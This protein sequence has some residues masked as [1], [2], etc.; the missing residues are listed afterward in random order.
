MGSTAK[1]AVPLLALGAIGVAT[2]GFGL[3]GGG[4]AAAGAGGAAAGAGA[5]AGTAATGAA[6]GTAAAGTAAGATGAGAAGASTG[7]WGWLTANSAPIGLGMGA[8]SALG[9]M[10]A[11]DQQ[12]Q[13]QEAMLAAQASQD[14]LALA[15]QENKVQTNLARTLAA[16]NVYFA[17]GG[18]APGSGSALAAA[19]SAESQAQRDLSSLYAQAAGQDSITGLRRR[20]LRSA[21]SG[22][23]VGSL[24]DF[25]GDVAGYFS[26]QAKIR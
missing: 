9:S 11:A 6:A 4:A 10:Q 7:L 24:L 13:Q 8:L 16:Q 2:G 14:K 19:N 18:V 23:Q 12:T 26:K 5:A 20:Q 17:S 25:G 1:I 3:L 22:G 21:R 15:D